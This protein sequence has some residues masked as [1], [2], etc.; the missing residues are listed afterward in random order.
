V[1]VGDGPSDHL[2]LVLAVGLHEAACATPI[3]MTG[4]G[5]TRVA[6]FGR[7]VVRV[8]PADGQVGGPGFEAPADDG[9]VLIAEVDAEPTHGAQDRDHGVD[10]SIF[11]GGVVPCGVVT[12]LAMMTVLVTSRRRLGA[13]PPT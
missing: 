8:R 13:G 6:V 2:A 10:G 4:Q 3:T 12:A 11:L 7:L 9:R 1:G 5:R